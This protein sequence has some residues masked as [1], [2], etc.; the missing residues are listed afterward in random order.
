[1]AFLAQK[2]RNIYFP[3]RIFTL[4]GFSFL[5]GILVASYLNIDFHRSE[6]TFFYIIAGLFATFAFN[7][8]VKN[9]FIALLTLSCLCSYLAVF[10][11]SYFEASH[12]KTIP[13][14]EELDWMG[15][16][17]KRPEISAQNQKI[18][19]LINHVESTN[20]ETIETNSPR[21]IIKAAVFPEYH[22]GDILKVRGKV[23]QPENFSDFDYKNYLKRWFVVG[24][25]NRPSVVNYMGQSAKPIDRIYRWLIGISQNFENSI[26]RVLPEPQASLSAGILLGIKRNIPDQIM[27][28]LQKTGLTHIIALSGFNVTIIINVFA[29]CLVIYLGRRQTFIAGMILV[30]LFVMMTGAAPSIVRA[31]IF[32]FLILFGRT[33]GRQADQI[34]LVLLTAIIMLFFNPYLLAY[35]VGFELSFLAFVGLVFLGQII[36]RLLEKN[37]R[38][39]LPSSIKM[40]LA[41]TIGAQL[42]VAPLILVKFGV[43]SLIAPISNLLVVW[44]VPW[45]ML[46]T[47]ISGILASIW[48]PLGKLSIIILWPGL[49]YILKVVELLAKVPYSS[50]SF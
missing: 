32:S 5:F 42:A 10:Y 26:N 9:K 47:F 21:I 20:G 4:L 29:A 6:I 33:I 36:H 12:Q 49:E 48:Y 8:V 13:F 18:V 23:S 50:L 45:V 41:E 3:Y 2:F 16:I 39:A 37:K 44:I 19:L 38:I 17:I 25:L 34:N 27:I 40:P 31:A 30:I 11:Y 46:L 24:E 28:D 7:V 43:V 15:E 35:D 14:G 22:F 1:M